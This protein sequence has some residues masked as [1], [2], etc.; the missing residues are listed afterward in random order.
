MGRT[1]AHTVRADV[2]QNVSG[3][4]PL[5]PDGALMAAILATCE[6]G[7]SEAIRLWRDVFR[8]GQ[9][10]SLAAG[11]MAEAS[12][13]LG[14][15]GTFDHMIA[16]C[17]DKDPLLATL[18]DDQ[19][20][21]STQDQDWA[22]G[23]WSARMTQNLS[24]FVK[25]HPLGHL[26]PDHIAE[27]PTIE[28][29][30]V[31]ALARFKAPRAP[32]V[33]DIVADHVD[34]GDL[35]MLADY[36][37]LLIERAASP[38]ALHWAILGMVRLGAGSDDVN[39]NALR[40]AFASY[41]LSAVDRQLADA[42]LYRGLGYT[43]L[44]RL[45]LRDALNV[46]PR[47]RDRAKIRRRLAKLAAENDRW[48]DDRDILSAADFDGRPDARE[49]LLALAG[50]SGT[51]VGEPLVSAFEWLL[52]Q[53]GID[54]VRYA[55]ENRLLMVGNALGCGGM[56]R[57]L[58]RSYRHFSDSG[59]FDTVDLALLDFS[60]GQASAFYA[61]EAGVTDD[62]VFV[63]G[64]DGAAEMPCA[65]LPGSWKVR[66]QK[67]YDHILAS[68]P[69]VIHAW[70]DLTGLLAAFAGLA[71]GCPKVII[72]FH[73]APGV[74]Q[75]GRAEQISSYPEIYRRLRVRPEV[76]TIFCAEAAA[77][78]YARWWH[79]D[80]DER[81]RVMYNGFD[82]D[83]SAGDKRASK[84]QLGISADAPVVGTVF[85][86]SAVKQP[87]LWAKAA[88]AFAKERPDAQFLM[89]GD[90]PMQEDVAQAFNDAGLGGSVIMPGRVDNVTDY[91]AAMDVFWLTSETEGLPNVLI[92]AQFSNVPVVAFDVGGASETFLPGVSGILVDPDDVSALVNETNALFTDPERL[93]EMAEAGRRN[94][95]VS[96]S[97]DA[98]YD[99]LN[100]AYSES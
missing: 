81:F 67:L 64:R 66:A 22:L 68:K 49:A 70:N 27:Y 25:D 34:K 95:A 89:V 7:W 46:A 30:R 3:A 2:W 16:H 76:T 57:I 31:G 37:Q 29:R 8:T 96:F 91:L 36:C 86:F 50:S 72:H 75:S 39:L 92:E 26:C 93:A 87:M 47:A 48:L 12:W 88:I 23:D 42:R 90:G 54:G 65:L 41:P 4:Q 40:R 44:A 78:G 55:P 53:S 10:D 19:C 5:V 33:Q 20:G 83:V 28:T 56:E 84:E 24:L 98:F 85:R 58:A 60:D 13:H 69:R 11:C 80:Q 79:V 71:A 43:A 100:R 32:A 15:D 63:L 77:R 61:G 97:A 18:S 38:D 99:R 94:A 73:H 21:D 52:D 45:I 74:P 14:H 1:L 51:G 62:D 59:Q 35:Q 6:G 82:W 17:P 9:H